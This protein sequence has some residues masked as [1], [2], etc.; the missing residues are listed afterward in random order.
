MGQVSAQDPL[1]ADSQLQGWG[2]PSYGLVA[3]CPYIAAGILY[4]VFLETFWLHYKYMTG[5]KIKV[6]CDYLSII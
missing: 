6:T 3:C 1:R 4:P 5:L 2:S